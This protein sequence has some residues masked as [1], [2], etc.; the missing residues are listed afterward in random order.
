[1]SKRV[2]SQDEVE[3][4][5]NTKIH[6]GM[7]GFVWKIADFS[8]SLLVAEICGIS[9]EQSRLLLS[10]CFWDENMCIEKQLSNNSSRTSAAVRTLNLAPQKQSI[11]T[12]NCC[13]EE[14]ET[15][16]LLRLEGCDHFFCKSCW[17]KFLEI[18]I[19]EGVTRL[20]CINQECN[21]LVKDSVLVTLVDPDLSFKHK[22]K[23]IT[24]FLSNSSLFIKCPK[25]ECNAITLYEDSES[26]SEHDCISCGHKWW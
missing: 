2:V 14:I 20:T 10:S 26:D 22:Q 19:R 23:F 3:R 24:S 1:M 25:K 21:N 8:V 12:C 11:A 6:K 5:M 17:N 4:L 7:N 13:L 9:F 18:K 16:E 15:N